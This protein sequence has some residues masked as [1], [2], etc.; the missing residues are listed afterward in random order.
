MNN[1]DF[2]YWLNKASQ[3]SAEYREKVADQPVRAQTAPGDIGQQ[4]SSSPP[5]E[6]HSMEDIFNDFV[7]I[8]PPGLTHWQHPRFFAYF[9][10]NAAPPAVV[11][12]LLATAIGAQCMLWQ[13][14]PAATELE[15]AM[16]DWLRQAVG[17][18]DSFKG[19]LQDTASSATLCAVLTMRELA[20]NFKGNADG[21]FGQPVLRVYASEH[22]H[23]SVDKAMWVAGLGQANLVKV[24]SD[25][26]FAML[27]DELEKAILDDLEAGR[28]PAGVVA[29][30]GGTSIGAT[31][32]VRA[33]CEVAKRYGLYTHVDAAWAGSAMICPEYRHFW[34]GV[35]LAD[36]MVLN[37]HK[38]LGAPMECSAHF[39]Q[40]PEKLV[41]TLAIQPEYLKTYGKDGII[42]FS[43]WG[44]QLGRRFRALKLW[45][46]LR[47]YGLDGLRERIR[48]HVA[49]AEMLASRLEDEK[50]FEVV[51]APM[52][53]LF[54]FRYSP[55]G[56]ED[57][58]AINLALVNKINDQ[59][60][61]YL[62]QSHFAGQL[63]IRFQA[64]QF[65]MQESDIE[66][67]YQAIVECARDLV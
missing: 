45:F 29:C 8:I 6:P 65:D 22:T 66:I 5:D 44:V 50:D 59:G 26:S 18:P 7:D 10:S 14:S 60:S 34:T 62:T 54:S 58:D 25:D 67:A 39:V 47:A 55:E 51:T 49:W 17:L 64:G 33:V 1:E 32:N 56:C 4:I 21:L 35:E 52:L 28:V 3:W 2:K 23:S 16:V 12:E 57:L 9:P 48:N 61:I 43:E 41:K 27:P 42:N 38:W 30:V 11:A 46:L 53:S 31:D 40:E 37:P 63:I 15:V 19:V 36:S 24:A 13:T 20:L